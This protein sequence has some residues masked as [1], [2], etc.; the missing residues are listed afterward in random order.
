MGSILGPPILGIYH[1]G[2]KLLEVVVLCGLSRIQ[3]ALNPRPESPKPFRKG[4]SASGEKVL[5]KK[6]PCELQSKLLNGDI[7]DDY[8]IIK[9][10]IRCLE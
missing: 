4:V 3:V 1:L 10:D 5:T 2:L 7:G 8:G 9:R 6:G